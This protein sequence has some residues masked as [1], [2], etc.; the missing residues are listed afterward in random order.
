ML[1]RLPIEGVSAPF[2][3]LDLRRGGQLIPSHHNLYADDATHPNPPQPTQRG[4]SIFCFIHYFKH[5]SI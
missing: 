3:Q 2:Q 4:Q 5:A 1:E